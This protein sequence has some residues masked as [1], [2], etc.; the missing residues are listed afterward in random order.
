MLHAGIKTVLIAGVVVTASC[1]GALLSAVGI[2]AGVGLLVY[3]AE[4]LA[5]L[6]RWT[7]ENWQ[8]SL[9]KK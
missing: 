6:D 8:E 2:L 9:N 7:E 5:D 1:G 3:G 4:K